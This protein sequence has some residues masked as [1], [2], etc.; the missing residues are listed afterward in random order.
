MIPPD[1]FLG[2]NFVKTL[3]TKAS[4]YRNDTPLTNFLQLAIAKNPY[5]LPKAF[6]FNSLLS[7]H[8]LWEIV[9]LFQ[10]CNLFGPLF[11]QKSERFIQVMPCPFTPSPTPPHA[12]LNPFPCILPPVPSS[13]FTIH[14]SLFTLHSS[15][16]TH[17]SSLSPTLPQKDSLRHAQGVTPPSTREAGPL[18][19]GAVAK[20][21]WGSCPS[22]LFLLHSSLFTVLPTPLP[23]P[24]HK[25]FTKRALRWRGRGS[26]FFQ[27]IDFIR[28]LRP[29][30]TPQGPTQPWPHTGGSKG[31]KPL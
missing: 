27:N 28:G 1:R 26:F 9:K 4:Q 23:P 18:F 5:C 19:E 3:F 8:F 12:F 29:P 14:S 2:S 25:L 15:L 13:L 6:C 16:F 31:A 7:Q 20:G 17:R 21:D 22:F 10:L 24:T 11:R 30:R